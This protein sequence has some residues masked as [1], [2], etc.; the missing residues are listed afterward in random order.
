MASTPLSPIASL[1]A[2]WTA[3]Q[4]AINIELSLSSEPVKWTKG[5][6]EAQFKALS[7]KVPPISCPRLPAPRIPNAI[8]QINYARNNPPAMQHYLTH[9]A[10]WLARRMLFQA[11]YQSRTQYTTQELYYFAEEGDAIVRVNGRPLTDVER[12]QL[13]HAPETLALDDCQ[14]AD[15]KMRVGIA[16]VIPAW[17]VYCIVVG[18][19]D[20]L[21]TTG[22]LVPR[23]RYAGKYSAVQVD[24]MTF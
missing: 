22:G 24:A 14:P 17:T 10:A 21:V 9:E 4:E 18:T 3:S 16:M 19:K 11:G 15:L 23:R 8:T 1:L 12:W 13:E 2:S 5:Q 6:V 7:T 20:T